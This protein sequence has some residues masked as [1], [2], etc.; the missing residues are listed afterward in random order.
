MMIKYRICINENLNFLLQL[1]FSRKIIICTIKY[2]NCLIDLMSSGRNIAEKYSSFILCVK[3]ALHKHSV[4]TEKNKTQYLFEMTKI[5][6]YAWSVITCEQKQY[7]EQ[8]KIKCVW[9]MDSRI[10]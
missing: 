1:C 6:I 8:N 7:N 3:F 9:T 10:I 5:K 4:I 2:S